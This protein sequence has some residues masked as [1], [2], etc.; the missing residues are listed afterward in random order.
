M[1]LAKKYTVE[2]IL[3]FFEQVCTQI[4]SS[5]Y[6]APHIWLLPPE[7]HS[8][9]SHQ[10]DSNANFG[11]LV[12]ETRD[13]LES[14]LFRNLLVKIL[15][16]SFQTLGGHLAIGMAVG[17]N[18]SNKME[19]LPLPKLFPVLLRKELPFILDFSQTS[20]EKTFLQTLFELP[21]LEEG[22]HQI[23]IQAY[24]K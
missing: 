19:A 24:D 9:P 18:Q 14:Q 13:I 5:P 17:D 4:E 16:H 22:S 21:E 12:D 20:N 10:S 1:Q 15:F 23:F 8:P 3:A 2:E 7:N 6:F 11:A